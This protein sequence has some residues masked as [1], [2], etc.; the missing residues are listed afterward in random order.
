MPTRCQQ[1]DAV[2]TSMLC[3]AEHEQAM[4]MVIWPM[5]MAICHGHNFWQDPD[6]WPRSHV[7]CRTGT[8]ERTG[9][10][11]PGRTGRGGRTGADGPGCTDR[12]LLDGRKHWKGIF[13]IL[14]VSC[15]FRIHQLCDFPVW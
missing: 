2:P 13:A 14:L 7:P 5:S 11:V 1:N 3:G 4:A 6:P 15:V 9:A 8:D 10:D 12:M